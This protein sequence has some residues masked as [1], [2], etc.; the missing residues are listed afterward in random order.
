MPMCYD[1]VQFMFQWYSSSP[2]TEHVVLRV[3]EFTVV[4]MYYDSSEY[5][6]FNFVYLNKNQS[7]YV[8]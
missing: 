1:L 2:G 7:E 8:G 4:P 3:N 6:I 5:K